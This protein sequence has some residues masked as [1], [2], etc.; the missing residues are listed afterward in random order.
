MPSQRGRI[1]RQAVA[2]APKHTIRQT[3]RKKDSAC[4]RMRAIDA[5]ITH[6]QD[7]EY[8]HRWKSVEKHLREEQG[9]KVLGLHIGRVSIAGR[10]Q[11]LGREGR[12]SAAESAGSPSL[13][14]WHS[15]RVVCGIVCG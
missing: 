11:G 7:P 4:A 5:F 8:D 13:T 14:L 3:C 12:V 6:G 1:V 10:L 15:L 9:M 2:G